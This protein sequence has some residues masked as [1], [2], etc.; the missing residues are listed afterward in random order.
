MNVKRFNIIITLAC[1]NVIK[2]IRISSLKEYME[3]TDAN[4][5]AHRPLTKQTLQTNSHTQKNI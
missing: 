5:S 3:N 2:K 4:T 1:L